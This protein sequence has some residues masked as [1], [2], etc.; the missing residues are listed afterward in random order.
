MAVFV[1]EVEKDSS[2]FVI[3]VGI[4]LEFA[5]YSTESFGEATVRFHIARVVDCFRDIFWVY[6]AIDMHQILHTETMLLLSS[7][8]DGLDFVSDGAVALSSEPNHRPRD[9]LGYYK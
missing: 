4:F 1:I 7:S 5:S 6:L 9:L 2:Y 3:I 8:E